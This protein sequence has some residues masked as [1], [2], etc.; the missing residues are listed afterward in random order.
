MEYAELLNSC[1][2]SMLELRNYDAAR[3]VFKIAHAQVVSAHGISDAS[4][5]SV[6]ANQAKLLSETGEMERAR[7]LFERSHATSQS[8]RDASLKA[9]EELSKLVMNQALHARVLKLYAEFLRR[10]G[11]AEAEAE[12]AGMEKEVKEL[13]GSYGFITQ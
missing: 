3:E 7:D 9:N 12:A 4:V 5:A 8:A 13:E 2:E 10:Q 1:G 11:G 6:E